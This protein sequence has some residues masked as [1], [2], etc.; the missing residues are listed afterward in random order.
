MLRSELYSGRILN[1][2]RKLTDGV[3]AYSYQA[4]RVMVLL[5]TALLLL[6]MAPGGGR[7]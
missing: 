1:T 4:L 3:T 7:N 2:M 6:A 5:L